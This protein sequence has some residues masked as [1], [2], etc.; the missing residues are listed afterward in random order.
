MENY[1]KKNTEKNRQLKRICRSSRLAVLAAA[2]L[3]A[4]ILLMGCGTTKLPENFDEAKVKAQAEL[5]LGYLNDNDLESFCQVP[6]TDKMQQV[7]TVESMETA[8]AQYM[9]NRGDFQEYKSITPVGTKDSDGNPCVA[10]VAVAQYENQRVTYTVS[11]NEE[12][13]MIGFFLK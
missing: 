2:G 10:V 9:G 6:M 5:V 3:L 4:G 1:K 7:T 12:L 8:V 13:E 11:F